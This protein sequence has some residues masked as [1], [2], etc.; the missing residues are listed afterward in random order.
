MTTVTVELTHDDVA[1]IV[2]ALADLKTPTGDAAWTHPATARLRD[3]LA[4]AIGDELAA[5]A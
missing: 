5:T 4:H 3:K 2:V 1:I